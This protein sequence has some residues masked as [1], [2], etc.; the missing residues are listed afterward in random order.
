MNAPDS[1]RAGDSVSW[2]ESLPEYSAVD[3]WALKYRFLW[4]TGSAITLAATASGSDYSVAL[5]PTDTAS[6]VA[7]SATLVSWVEKTGARV[8]LA[9]KS[10][11]I[12]PDLAIAGTFDGRSLAVHALID[13]RAALAAYMA[14]GQIHVGEY[15][16]AG[17]RMKFRSSVEITDL[18]QY[19]ER[20]VAK[21]RALQAAMNG[22]S[23]G[24]V[25]VRF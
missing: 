8:L 25:C 21:E 3:G 18:I 17:R 19:Y 5:T 14:K 6:W 12:L 23:A 24:R 11:T 22:V 16:I 7:G 1:F 15:D 9:Q 10:I 2:D 20:E 4:P 13:A